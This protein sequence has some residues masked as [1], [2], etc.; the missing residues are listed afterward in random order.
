[1]YGGFSCKKQTPPQKPVDGTLAKGFIT[2]TITYMDK[3]IAR[4]R[5][6]SNKML[7]LSYSEPFSKIIELESDDEEVDNLTESS[8]DE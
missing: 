5:L 7:N 6:L 1:M 2:A 3:Q 8:S 4:D